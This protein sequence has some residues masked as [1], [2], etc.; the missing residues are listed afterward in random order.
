M[1]WN[2]NMPISFVC[3][4]DWR[5]PLVRATLEQ[6]FV[7]ENGGPFDPAPS[8]EVIAYAAKA[9]AWPDLLGDEASDFSH[10]FH[11]PKYSDPEGIEERV[12][13][14]AEMLREAKANLPPLDFF[15][16]LK[17]YVAPEVTAFDNIK[18]HL[19]ALT[20]EARCS[21]IVRHQRL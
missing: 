18:P 11:Y 4:D 17:E 9:L 12:A 15:A 7:I 21:L 20:W 2:A 19:A 6:A 10:F 14:V 13:K 16:D 8:L 3:S 1:I 5:A